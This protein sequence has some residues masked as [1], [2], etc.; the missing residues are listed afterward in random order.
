MS[1]LTYIIVILQYIKLLSYCN[2]FATGINLI[3]IPCCKTRDAADFNDMKY[4]ALFFIS[5][6]TIIPNHGLL[7]L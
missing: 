7:Y 6:I 4:D 3:E 2:L 5:A 1:E